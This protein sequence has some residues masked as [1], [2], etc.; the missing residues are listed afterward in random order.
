MTTLRNAGG[1]LIV[2]CGLD[3]QGAALAMAANIAGAV[4]L[5]IEKRP[6]ILKAALRSGS[7]DFIVNSV[8]EALRAMKNEIRKHLPISVGLQGDPLHVLEELIGRGVQ[9][10]LLTDLSHICNGQTADRIKRQADAM[11]SLRRTGA[12]L[13]D[14]NLGGAT[15]GA[16]DARAELGSYV[17]NRGWD[18]QSFSLESAAVLKAFDARTLSSPSEN[19]PLRSRWLRAA[20]RILQRQRP[21]RRV[22]WTTPQEKQMLLAELP[23]IA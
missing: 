14:F 7:C 10:E 9:P 15:E 23:P 16:I 21:L 18:L 6:E 4:C 12:T 1:G 3:E 2:C 22:L 17:F 11:Q 13:V 19:D 20:S 5:S 8:D